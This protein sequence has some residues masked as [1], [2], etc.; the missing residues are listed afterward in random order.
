MFF[1]EKNMI[2]HLHNQI[3]LII[4]TV[5]NLKRNKMKTKT[6][7]TEDFKVGTTL[8]T[9]EGFEF[10]ITSKYDDGIW[11]ARGRRGSMCVFENEAKF[12]TI[13]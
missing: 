7:T 4:F 10:T 9:V 1:N 5:S 3:N 12:Y 6:A 2:K 13:K 8:V 11:E